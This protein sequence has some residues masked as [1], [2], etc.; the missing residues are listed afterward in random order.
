MLCDINKARI[1]II[2]QSV[3]NFITKVEIFVDRYYEHRFWQMPQELQ[4][5]TKR[6][7]YPDVS[8]ELERDRYKYRSEC[9]CTI[10]TTETTCR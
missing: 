8:L 4:L 1:E 6:V 9:R 10:Y 2:I 3:V 7:E 5:Y